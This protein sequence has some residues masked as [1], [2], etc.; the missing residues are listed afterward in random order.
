LGIDC[1]E[2]EWTDEDTELVERKF[3]IYEL[4]APP[5]LAQLVSGRSSTTTTTSNRASAKLVLLGG[6]RWRSR[7]RTHKGRLRQGAR[8]SGEADLHARGDHAST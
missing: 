4:G 3:S 7:N 5:K 1:V 2:A 6:P 8:Y